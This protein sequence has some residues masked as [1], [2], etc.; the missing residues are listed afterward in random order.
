MVLEVTSGPH[1]TVSSATLVDLKCDELNCPLCSLP[2]PVN[3]IVLRGLC[4]ETIFDRD[5]IARMTEDGSLRYT[6][7]HTSFISYNSQERV[8]LLYDRL[9]SQSQAISQSSESSLLLGL[10]TFDMAGV[11][12]DKCAVGRRDSLVRLK[13]TACGDGKFTCNDGECVSMEERCNQISNCRDRSDEENCQVVVMEENYNNKISPFGF[14]PDTKKLIPANVD[15]SIAIID[16][17]DISEVDLNYVLKFRLQMTW[18]DYRLV[19][20]N[21]KLERSE[22]SL[23]KAAIEKLWIPFIVFSN[24]VHN[25]HTKGEE[26]TELTITRE[27]DF[28]RSSPEVVEEID[29]FTGIENTLTF[30]Q[31]FAKTFQ[32]KY[33]LQLYPFDTQVGIKARGAI[34]HHSL[35]QC[36]QCPKENAFPKRDI[37]LKSKLLKTIP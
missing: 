10:H 22:N 8:W 25:E 21:L 23:T 3:H 14:D 24:T 6:G 5:Y 11:R 1:H 28:V 29:I 19:Y 7:H 12:E 30:Q 18:K 27:G 20:H 4:K 13:L 2:T 9:H 37:V 32:C 17:I 16:V 34:L 33:Q 15:I 36:E 35:Y 26:D 31:V